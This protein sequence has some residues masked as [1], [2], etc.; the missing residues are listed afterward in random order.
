MELSII[1]VNYNVKYYV[2][3]CLISLQRALGGIDAE[4]FVVDNHSHDGSMEYLSSRYKDVNFIS[5]NHNYGFSRAN[6]IAIKQCKGDFILLLNP[7]TIVGEHTLA[8]V[9]GF[10]RKEKNA[11]AVGVRMLKTDGSNAL[12]SRRGL[13]TPMTAFYKMSGLCSRYPQS[14]RFGRYYM[15]FLPWNKPSKIEI[16][17]GAF[18]MIRREAIDKVGLLDEQFFMYGEDIDL[19]YRILK[20]GFDNWYFPSCILHYKGTSTRK[21]SFRYVHVFY[22]AML[23]FFRKHFGHM[24]ALLGIPVKCAIYAK[25][26]IEMIRTG[27]QQTRKALGFSD[28]MA[29]QQPLYV[30]IGSAEM[31]EEC[32]QLA[33]RNGLNATF[34]E[35]NEQ[36]RPNGHT[37][38][39]LPDGELINIVY[40]VNAYRFETIFSIFADRN[41]PNVRIGTYNTATQNIITAEEII[42]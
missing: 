12:E 4:V 40:D 30:F 27:L 19:S 38:L 24:G 5:C 36:S 35:G 20:G 34:H 14:R 9:L 11:G 21:S 13:P 1:I 33:N 2:E 31:L 25:A 6:N 8:D 10:M 41:K 22:G 3:Q 17:S 42:R 26:F 15:G 28:T 7:D 39:K 29:L 32:R 18:C 23:I 37:D 16:V